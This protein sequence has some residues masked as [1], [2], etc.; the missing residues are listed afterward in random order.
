MSDKTSGSGS[1]CFALPGWSAVTLRGEQATAFAQAQFM[2]DLSDLAPG[3]WQWN[4]WLTPKGRLV[5]LFALL[6]LDGRDLALLLPDADPEAFVAALTR[7]RFRTRVEIAHEGGWSFAGRFSAPEAARGAAA[8]GSVDGGGL[9]LDFGGDG[10]P[11]TLRIAASP[12]PADEA[13]AARWRRE[14]LAHGLPRLAPGQAEQ[15]TPQQLSL[16]RLRAFSVHK[17]CYPG[18]EIVARTH[19]LGQAKRG[20]VRL[21][22]DQMLAVAP[23][24]AVD[25]PGRALG[26]V[27]SVAGDQ[28]LAVMPLD[29]GDGPFH[30]QGVACTPL[31]L[32]DGLAR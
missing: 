32:L 27:V 30:V 9:E 26:Q 10:G 28:A 12:V 21:A 20:L 6:A 24:A 16:E 23:V 14:D 11:R 18:Q 1:T 7:F 3:R 25:A 15:W 19:F 4:G 5:A 22:G 2:G 17:G 13:Q 31:P 29:A 8:S